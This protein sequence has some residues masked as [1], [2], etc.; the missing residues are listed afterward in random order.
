MRVAMD[1]STI[2]T[3]AVTAVHTFLAR[4][5]SQLG[6]R[7][8]D[9]VGRGLYEAV[10][11]RLA[12]DADSIERLRRLEAQ[13][14]DATNQAALRAVMAATIQADP[15]FRSELLRLFDEG[16]AAQSAS[17]SA[18]MSTHN[19][20]R[21]GRMSRS[22]VAFGPMNVDA[23]RHNQIRRQNLLPVVAIAAVLAV[24]AGVVGVTRQRWP[25][26]WEREEQG[27]A[28]SAGLPAASGQAS[29]AATVERAAG[30]AVGLASWPSVA[31]PRCPGVRPL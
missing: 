5:G 9:D 23:S 11:R 14:Q 24:M 21:V 10:K 19:E 12:L 17:I 29:E 2:A 30:P 26:P 8:G 18:A 6:E 7:T 4:V 28:E 25:I 20:L 31:A 15:G 1:A 22:N 27:G 13:P 3:V 16:E